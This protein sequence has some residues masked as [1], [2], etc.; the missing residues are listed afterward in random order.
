MLHQI[1]TQTSASGSRET[2][3]RMNEKKQTH[4]SMRHIEIS[5]AI[6]LLAHSALAIILHDSGN[7]VLYLMVVLSLLLLAFRRQPENAGFKSL[8]FQNWPLHLAMA[9]LFLS[10]LLNQM[11]SGKFFL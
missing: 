9:S 2:E 7:A 10:L 5:I 6:L 4:H 3:I 1:K 11:H 8:F